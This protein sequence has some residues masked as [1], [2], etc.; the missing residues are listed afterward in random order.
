VTDPNDADTDG[1]GVEDL[2][3]IN[4]GTDPTD[5]N[6][7]P[8]PEVDFS[9]ASYSVSE[10]GGSAVVTVVLTDAPGSGRTASVDY[11]TSDGSA[12]AGSDYTGTSGT[13]NFSSSESSKTFSVAIIE[14]GG[15]EESETVTLTLSNAVGCALAGVNNP[16]TLTIVD[17]DVDSD[18]DGI[19]DYDERTATG[20]RTST[21][22]TGA[23]TRPIRTTP[24]RQFLRSLSVQGPIS[25]AKASHRRLLR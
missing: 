2:D 23:P 20:S 15:I 4:G 25:W 22:S 11:A 21:R 19:S 14:D 7:P 6:D 8:S 12:T 16:A 24:C 10:D 1:D 18:G 5:P 9:S 17:N 3:E 13:L